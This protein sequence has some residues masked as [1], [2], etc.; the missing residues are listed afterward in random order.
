MLGSLGAQAEEALPIL[1]QMANKAR[2]PLFSTL[3]ESAQKAAEK[4]KQGL[5][6]DKSTG[7]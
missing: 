1:E 5:S 3:Q 7:N 6:K 2:F 4:I